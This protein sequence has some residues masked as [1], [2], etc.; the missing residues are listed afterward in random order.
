MKPFTTFSSVVYHPVTLSGSLAGPVKLCGVVGEKQAI[1]VTLSGSLAG[2]VK[3][4]FRRGKSAGCG[5]LHYQVHW[6]VQ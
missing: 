4:G 3:H 2:P 1:K 5:R 6:R